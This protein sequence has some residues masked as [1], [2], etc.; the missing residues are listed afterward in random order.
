MEGR[1][2][3]RL[4]LQI[5]PDSRGEIGQLVSEALFFPG[6]ALDFRLTLNEDRHQVVSKVLS[7]DGAFI[8]RL[9]QQ[10]RGMF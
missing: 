1:K 8:V 4:I 6:A 9:I 7:C 10:G 2:S 5:V 3:S